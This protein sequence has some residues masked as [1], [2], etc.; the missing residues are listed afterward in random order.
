MNYHINNNTDVRHAL[1]IIQCRIV[2]ACHWYMEDE[3]QCQIT[4]MYKWNHESFLLFSMSF[5]I[6]RISWSFQNLT[7]KINCIYQTQKEG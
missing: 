7:E 4:T 1:K 5:S 2:G 6:H 3:E